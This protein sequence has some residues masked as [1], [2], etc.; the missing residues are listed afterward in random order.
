MLRGDSSMALDIKNGF[1]IPVLISLLLTLVLILI[2]YTASILVSLDWMSPARSV[3]VFI[4]PLMVLAVSLSGAISARLNED[5]IER[6][7][8]PI[9]TNTYDHLKLNLF[10]MTPGAISGIVAFALLFILPA[11]NPSLLGNIE[12]QSSAVIFIQFLAPVLFPAL[13]FFGAWVYILV[14]GKYQYEK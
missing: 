4:F 11:I 10:F 14:Y 9:Y 12:Y 1:I 8:S 2:D 7:R 5:V 6:A 3:Q 13:S